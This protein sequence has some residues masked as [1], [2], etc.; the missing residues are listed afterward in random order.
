MSPDLA[1]VPT[2]SI[3]QQGSGRAYFEVKR[4]TRL[5]NVSRAGY[6]RWKSA[7][8]RD[9]PPPPPGGAGEAGSAGAD[10]AVHHRESQGTYGSPRI[11]ADL[12][13]AGLEVNVKTVAEAMADMDIAGISRVPTQ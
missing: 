7:T 9:E 1:A 4:M 12:H 8:E 10:R 2:T 11:T 5:L 3:N 6:Y 13:E